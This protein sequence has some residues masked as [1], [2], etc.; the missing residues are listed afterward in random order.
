MSENNEIRRWMDMEYV[1]FKDAFCEKII[2][3][4]PEKYQEITLEIQEHEDRLLNK[5]IEHASFMYK[6]Q[7][8][9][10]VQLSKLFESNREKITQTGIEHFLLELSGS[11]TEAIANAAEKKHIV[12]D[13]Q[14]AN[15][16]NHI[17]S[18]REGS[19]YDVRCLSV[20]DTLKNMNVFQNI[21]EQ[22]NADLYIF[23]FKE[24]IIIVPESEIANAAK[25]ETLRKNIANVMMDDVDRYGQC[26]YKYLYK[27][28][29][30][31]EWNV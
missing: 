31:K 25:K 30:L 15:S 4:L 14:K 10:T 26:Y 1:V 2:Q 27:E 9:F 28:N 7:V 18:M 21:S 16:E 23:P 8:L 13:Q 19:V 24:Q 3:Y 11:V 29:V 17:V 6:N 12:F 5:K 22:E 20:S